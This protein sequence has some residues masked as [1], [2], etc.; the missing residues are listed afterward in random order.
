MSYD[1][2]KPPRYDIPDG[3]LILVLDGPFGPEAMTMTSRRPVSLCQP[4]KEHSGRIRRAS[5]TGLKD[6]DFL[7]PN[8]CV[9]H[10]R[11]KKENKEWDRA[12][13]GP[14]R[15][16]VNGGCSAEGCDK[17]AV[18]RGLCGTHYKRERRAAAKG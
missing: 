7:A 13:D 16:R 1:P 6:L 12:L 4:C 18:A 10:H 17:A 9:A 8:L 15:P 3:D 11:L 2:F 5:N 14:G